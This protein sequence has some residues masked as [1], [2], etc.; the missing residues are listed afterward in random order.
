MNNVAA[1]LLTSVVR[2]NRESV[3]G[4]TTDPESVKAR[5]ERTMPE[6]DVTRVPEG[7]DRVDGVDLRTL[8]GITFD[9]RTA[10]EDAQLVEYLNEIYPG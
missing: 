5:I 2:S 10:E 9:G 7:P 4:A 1:T 8:P 6:G 3:P